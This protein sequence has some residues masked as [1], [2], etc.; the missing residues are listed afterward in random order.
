MSADEINQS[1]KEL[2]VW[3]VHGPNWDIDVPLD[4]F[5]TQ[6]DPEDQAYEAATR[7][8]AALKGFNP[9]ELTINLAKGESETF[10]GTTMIVHLKDADPMSGFVPLTHVVLANDGFYKESILMEQKFQEQI[11]I[12]KAQEEEK[13][14][15]AADLDKEIKN[16]EKFK[17]EM[18]EKAPKQKGKT[19]K[20]IKP[21]KSE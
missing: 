9:L 15:R 2:P 10:L 13:K 18:K 14:K 21:P 16:F 20:S 17:Q 11:D 6:F 8:I 4:E 3:T 7:A 19:K 12:L 1:I 5:N